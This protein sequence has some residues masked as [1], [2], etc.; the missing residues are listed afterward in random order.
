MINRE[1]LLKEFE[2]LVAIDS[3]SYGERAMADYLTGRLQELGLSVWEDKAGEQ[4]A[5]RRNADAKEKPAGVSE[6]GAAGN[7]YGFLPGNRAGEPLLFSAHMDTVTPG[8][9]KRAVFHPDGRI[10]SAGDTVLGADD[11]SG[12]AA[13]LEALTII[14]EQG[15]PHPDIEVLFPVAEEAYGQ[16]SRLFDYG[17]LRA[18]QAYVLDLSGKV[19][20]AALAAPTILAVKITI[21]GKSAHAGF[22]PEEGI[23]AI[24]IAARALAALP[25][26]RVDEETTVNL[27]QIAGGNAD[28][29]V[30][31]YCRITGEIRSMAHEKAME[32]AKRLTEAFEREAAACGG[33]A[34]V[35]VEEQVHAYR[36][37]EQSEVV[38]RFHCACRR[39][40]FEENLIATFGG[41]DNNHFVRHGLEGIVVSCAMSSV[42][43]KQE[44]TTEQELVNCGELTLTLMTLP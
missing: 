24:A 23:H 42:H 34:E 32:Q 41:S 16:G 43:T 40:G 5:E 14:R 27:G 37:S 44:Y 21:H 15:I 6:N 39:N 31:D 7:L 35:S 8:K 25:N 22:A 26:G 17:A 13:I 12:I 1:R 19:G 10:T 29:I 36:I 30:P 11:V 4:L 3:E 2:T 38:Q 18:K 28:N 20:T 9:G 33:S